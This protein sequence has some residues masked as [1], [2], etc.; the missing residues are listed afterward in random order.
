MCIHVCVCMHTSVQ[1][2]A[3]A[4][5]YH[6]YTTPPIARSL[7]NTG[8]QHA[9]YTVLGN[10]K[11]ASSLW[12]NTSFLFKTASHLSTDLR[13]IPR[14]VAKELNGAGLVL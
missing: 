5:L 11:A 12:S 6:R 10:R 14:K 2:A 9:P 3:A 7:R 4:T 1:E 13:I 8:L